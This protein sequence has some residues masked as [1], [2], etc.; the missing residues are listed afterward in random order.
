MKLSE[1]RSIL[2]VADQL[3]VQEVYIEK[4]DGDTWYESK[5]KVEGVVF[6]DCNSGATPVLVIKEL[7]NVS[8]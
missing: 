8:T 5:F 2:K 6:E 1:L 7:S 4:V 3:G